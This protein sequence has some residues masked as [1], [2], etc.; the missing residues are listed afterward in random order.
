MSVLKVRGED[1]KWRSIPSIKGEDGDATTHAKQHAIGGSDELTPADI[2]AASVNHAHSYSEVGASPADHTHTPAEIGA[3]SAD[4]NHDERYYTKE[5][6]ENKL[7]N[8]T[9]WS[10]GTDNLEAGVSSLGTGRLYFVYE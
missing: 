5:E 10:Y 4:H 8:V 9:P 6:T 1:G 7:S 3:A 2:G